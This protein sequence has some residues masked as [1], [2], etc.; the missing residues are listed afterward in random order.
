[1][2]EI[3]FD[4]LSEKVGGRF[5]L[6][7]MIIRRTRNMLLSSSAAEEGRLNCELIRQAIEEIEEGKLQLR[8]QDSLESGAETPAS[9]S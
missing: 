7:S 6:C 3:D 8:D 5:K 2:I 1:M 4:Q 9:P